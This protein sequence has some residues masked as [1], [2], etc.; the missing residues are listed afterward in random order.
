MHY[1]LRLMKLDLKVRVCHSY[2]ETNVCVDA[3]A[4]L[5]R[6]KGGLAIVYDHCSSH[7]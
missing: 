4:N 7:I 5:T 1:I 6:D 2:H 3:L